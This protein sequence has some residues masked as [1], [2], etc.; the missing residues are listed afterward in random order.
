GLAKGRIGIVGLGPSAPGAMEGLL[1]LGF[2]A[3]LTKMVP[4][5]TLEDFTRDMTD[6]ML[7]KSEEELALLRFAA[8]V[9]EEAC[10]AMIEASRPGAGEAEVYAAI[11]YAIHRRGCDTRYPFLTLQSGPDNIG[12]GVPRWTLRAEPPRILE[13]G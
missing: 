9:S 6:F 5:A 4:E 7:V 8:Q 12:W 1:P 10:E 2:H 3:S 11:M 13:A